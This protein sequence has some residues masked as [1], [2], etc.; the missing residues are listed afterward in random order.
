M[1]LSPD[2]IGLTSELRRFHIE[3]FILHFDFKITLTSYQASAGR[4]DDWLYDEIGYMMEH[5]V[6]KSIE[7][8]KAFS[9]WLA[10]VQSAWIWST[11]RI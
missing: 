3:T 11:L 1:L 8:Y 10:K 9:D 2:E 4:D 7:P 6:Q 5:L